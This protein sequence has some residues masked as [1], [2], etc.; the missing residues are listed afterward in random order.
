MS[1]V[2][3]NG[4]LAFAGLGVGLVCAE[5]ALRLY[6]RV[7]GELGATL[8]A[9]DPYRILIEPHGAWGYRPRPNSRYPYS[10]GTVAT[11]NTAGY[12]GPV[13]SIPK[14]PETFRIVLLG[15]SATHGFGVNDGETIDSFMR[16]I[17]RE[18]YPDRDMEVVNLAF[19]GYDSYQLLQR[20]RSDGLRMDPDLVIVNTGINDVRNAQFQDLTRAD[21][22]TVLWIHV[23][24]RLLG[25]AARGGPTLWTRVKHHSYLARLPGVLRHFRGRD[26]GLAAKGPR[27][28]YEDAV[29]YFATNLQALAGDAAAKG[30]PVILSVAP[31]SFRLNYLPDGTT[32][33]TYWLATPSLTQDYRDRLARRLRELAGELSA[34]GWAV[35][36]IDHELSR[37]MFLDDAHLTVLGNRTLARTF[38][39]AAAPLIEAPDR[40]GPEPLADLR[41]RSGL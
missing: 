12:R 17:L 6:A 38:V 13:V 1:G 31:S 22:R 34:R 32:P 36:F 25:E 2:S 11:S 9:W 4:V 40:R 39:E 16:E 41:P 33:R 24:R 30:V 29:D 18:R 37:E 35:R 21:P 26:P 27:I 19:D 8:T 28:V 5:G 23:L 7:G 15:G 3:L 20:F 10:N 14:P